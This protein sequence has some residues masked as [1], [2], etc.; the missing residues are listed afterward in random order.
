MANPTHSYDEL[1][2]FEVELTVEDANGMRST[3]TQTVDV[4]NLAPGLDVPIAVESATS[5]TCR[6]T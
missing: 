2:S 4:R 6:S 5:R 3:T 1:G